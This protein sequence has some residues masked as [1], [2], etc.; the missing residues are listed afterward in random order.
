MIE[1]FESVLNKQCE[2]VF[3]KEW[4]NSAATTIEKKKKKERRKKRNVAGVVIV[5]LLY[6]NTRI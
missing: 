4:Q 2:F 1:I 3:R 6:A 5:V